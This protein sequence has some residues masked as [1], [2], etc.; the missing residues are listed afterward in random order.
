ML[1]ADCGTVFQP[2]NIQVADFC[3]T[4]VDG[5]G[6]ERTFITDQV[7]IPATSQNLGKGAGLMSAV[8]KHIT[9][10][11]HGHREPV[12]IYLERNVLKFDG[13]HFS[14]SRVNQKFLERFSTQ[15][16]VKFLLMGSPEQPFSK[17]PICS[18]KRGHLGLLS[19][20]CL[21][22]NQTSIRSAPTPGHHLEPP[23][24]HGQHQ[25]EVY[26]DPTPRRALLQ[27]GSLPI[28]AAGWTL[29]E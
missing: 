13:E 1:H 8:Q 20:V 4:S 17:L 18:A 16:P 24:G 2:E 26:P 25:G 21:S 27:D 6:I 7:T 22:I 23:Q 29:I 10:L 12:L 9:P 28:R 19:M 14:A 15:T 5:T 3:S 11:S